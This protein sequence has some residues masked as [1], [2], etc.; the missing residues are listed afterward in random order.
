MEDVADAQAVLAARARRCAE[1]SGQLRARHD[2]V[3]DVV[4][5]ADAAHRGEGGLASAPD[6]R[7]VVGVGGDADLARAVLAAHSSTAREIL[8]DL[9]GRA[10]E[11]DDQHGAAPVG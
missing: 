5:G 2:A 3:L 6:A 9:R 10:V 11:L 4:V 1:H 7:A 8:L